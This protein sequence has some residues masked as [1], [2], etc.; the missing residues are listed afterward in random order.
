[1]FNRSQKC[2]LSTSQS[3]ANDL[4]KRLSD[5]NISEDKRLVMIKADGGPDWS[6]KSQHILI[7]MGKVFRDF[8][9]AVFILAASH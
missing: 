2:E 5:P 3:H 1:M 7:S 9:F 8:H 6:T 4:Y